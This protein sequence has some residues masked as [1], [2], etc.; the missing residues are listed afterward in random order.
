VPAFEYESVL[1]RHYFI[2]QWNM[3]GEI[4]GGKDLAYWT[5]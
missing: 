4:L 1:T 3:V 5:P 2:S